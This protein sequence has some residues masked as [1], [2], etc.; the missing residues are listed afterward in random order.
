VY[1]YTRDAS[2]NPNPNTLE[3]G[4]P[5]HDRPTAC[6]IGQ[7]Y[8]SATFVCLPFHTRKEEFDARF[9]NASPYLFFKMLKSET[10]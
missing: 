9:T 6:A 2:R 10:A 8:S 5:Q 7:Q 1:V 4:R 3:P